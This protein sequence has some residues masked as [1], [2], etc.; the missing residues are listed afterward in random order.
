MALL[1]NNFGDPVAEREKLL[2]TFL[3]SSFR[4][5]RRMAVIEAEQVKIRVKG[6]L[7]LFKHAEQPICKFSQIW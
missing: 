6:Y 5:A 2:L 1:F 3:A 4:N 7:R